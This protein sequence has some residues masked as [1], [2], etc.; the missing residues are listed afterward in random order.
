[1]KWLENRRFLPSRNCEEE[2]AMRI[3]KSTKFM[4]ASAVAMTADK[5]ATTWASIKAKN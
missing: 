5:L 2:T 3:L 1:L 4:I